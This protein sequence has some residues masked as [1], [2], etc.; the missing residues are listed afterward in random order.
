[1]EVANTVDL[2]SEVD[3][4]NSKVVVHVYFVLVPSGDCSIHVL[5]RKAP[6]TDCVNGAVLVDGGQTR[7]K[8]DAPKAIV[9]SISR[10]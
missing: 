8:S 5:V 4:N 10:T 9:H 6:V 7:N 3:D 1:M 2:F